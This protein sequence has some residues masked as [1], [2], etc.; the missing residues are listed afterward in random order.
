MRVRPVGAHDTF[1][2]KPQLRGRANAP[3]VEESCRDPLVCADRGV[4]FVIS[5]RCPLHSSVPEH[6]IEDVDRDRVDFDG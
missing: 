6:V 2:P 5:G 4:S 3:I 1:I